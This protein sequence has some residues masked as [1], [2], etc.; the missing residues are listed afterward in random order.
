[1]VAM[2]A[3]YPLL[4]VAAAVLLMVDFAAMYLLS[5]APYRGFDLTAVEERVVVSASAGEIPLGAEVVSLASGNDTIQLVPTDLIEEP[6][7]LETPAEMM[8]FFDRQQRLTEILSAGELRVTTIDGTEYIVEQEMWPAR[9]KPFQFGLQLVV[10]NI[11]MLVGVAVFAFQRHNV[12]ARHFCVTGVGLAIAAI[13]AAVY[14]SRP[15]ALPGDVFHLLSRSNQFGTLLFAAAFLSLMWHYPKALSERT[16]ARWAYL[17]MVVP[18]VLDY[19]Q[20]TPQLIFTRQLPP[21]LVLIGAA[22]ILVVQWRRSKGDLLTRQSLKWFIFITMSGSTFFV[23][24]IM[25]PVVLDL[26]LAVSQGAAFVAFLSIYVGLAVGIARY[27]LFDLDRYW[28]RAVYW[29]CAGLMLVGVDLVVVTVFSVSQRDAVWLALALFG[30][31]YF[32]LRTLATRYVF[33]GTSARFEHHLPGIITTIASN[34]GSDLRNAW[35]RQLQTLFAPLECKRESLPVN[36]TVV[37]KR[38]LGLMVPGIDGQ[39]SY[40]LQH[41]DNGRRLFSSDDVALVGALQQLFDLAHR[42]RTARDEGV[43]QERDRIKRDIHDSLGG[44]LL[45][46]LHRASDPRIVSESRQAM[47]ELRD[48]LAAVEDQ[49][50]PL[51]ATI[52]KWHLQV[53]SQVETFGVDLRWRVGENLYSID[54]QLGG[55][56][57]LSLGRIITEAITNALRHAG[58]RSIDVDFSFVHDTL[59][60]TIEND[61]ECRDPDDWYAGNGLVN[62]RKRA[63]ELGGEV[64]WSLTDEGALPPRMR[65]S[66]SVPLETR[67]E[68]APA[69][70]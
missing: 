28:I 64:H 40:V 5:D 65:F 12:A 57:R 33:H 20:L 17:A 15:V 7:Q 60:L 18:C 67:L 41:A 38:G 56:S 69:G 62:I 61:G 48:I 37:V 42:A 13:V 1:M 36:N 10:G 47:N 30:W 16:F 51:T 19:L 68:L 52:E 63:E 43:R 11:G 70:A 39:G 25:L 46:I 14:S 29:A 59:F 3:P 24:T 53:L 66:L 44:R 50:S 34:P 26:S 4:G 49:D 32:P 31:L 54:W 35:E 8:V 9:P 23:V 6:D 22:V 55:G 21:V 45:T 2:L 58:A 27:P